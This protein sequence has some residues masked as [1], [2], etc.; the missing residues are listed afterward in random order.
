MA[1]EC[2]A[3]QTELLR[4]L[5][6]L[7]KRVATRSEDGSGDQ[8]FDKEIF[9]LDFEWWTLDSFARS[10][11]VNSRQMEELNSRLTRLNV[12]VT[13]AL[14]L[15]E[16]QEQRR[17]QASASLIPVTKPEPV[18]H[19][20]EQS[21]QP[22]TSRM[23]RYRV[24]RHHQA[25]EKLSTS[26]TDEESNRLRKAKSPIETPR[27]PARRGIGFSAF[28]RLALQKSFS[29]VEVALS[30]WDHARKRSD[31]TGSRRNPVYQSRQK[32]TVGH[33]NGPKEGREHPSLQNADSTIPVSEYVVPTT[34]M[35]TESNVRQVETETRPSKESDSRLRSHKKLQRDIRNR[36]RLLA[37]KDCVMSGAYG[38]PGSFEEDGGLEGLILRLNDAGEVGLV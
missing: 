20:R 26:Q 9:E 31:S 18:F 1:E 19:P 17:A 7:E 2:I 14:N 36:E 21:H 5:P 11:L 27:Q 16:E 3:I 24:K 34:S 10:G 35:K 13:D 37:S 12:R 4:L 32:M 38:P 33:E 30:F 29:V 6:Q 8:Y 23:S 15:F 28:G 22:E 25:K